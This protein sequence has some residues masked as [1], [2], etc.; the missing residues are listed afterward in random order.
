[1]RPRNIAGSGSW[2]VVVA[3]LETCSFEVTGF[4]D[5]LPFWASQV[6]PGTIWSGNELS[7]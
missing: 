4:L 3:Y 2:V 5:K 1:M 7:I 6:F